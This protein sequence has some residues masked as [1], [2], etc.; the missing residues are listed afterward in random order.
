[1]IIAA[2]LRLSR[3]DT[4]VEDLRQKVTHILEKQPRPI[5]VMLDDIDRL[6]ANEIWNVLKLVRLTANFPNMIYILT[7]DQLQVERTLDEQGFSGRDFLKKIIQVPYDLPIIPTH[8]IAEEIR[9]SLKDIE[10]FE[11]LDKKTWDSNVEAIQPFFKNIRDI[12]RYVVSF[13]WTMSSLKDRVAPSDVLVLEALRLFQPDVFRQFPNRID[14]LTGVSRLHQ[15][16]KKEIEEHVHER[17]AERSIR[18]RPCMD[19]LPPDIPDVAYL[20]PSESDLAAFESDSE[21]E[22]EDKDYDY[23]PSDADRLDER[24]REFTGGAIDGQSHLVH[25]MII[26]AFPNARWKAFA[27]NHDQKG[28]VASKEV[29]QMYLDRLS[30]ET[31]PDPT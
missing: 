24:L 21:D 27:D 7:F 16:S 23:R 9:R 28:R 6:S 4:S 31:Q 3:R 30:D 20:P 14:D 29:L 5:I 17:R 10:T 18:C 15:N 25:D 8:I 19:E 22:E 2:G 26:R 1:M 13:Q 11:W 12:R